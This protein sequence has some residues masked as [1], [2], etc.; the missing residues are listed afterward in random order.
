MPRTTVSSW[1]AR[2]LCVCVL[3]GLSAAHAREAVGW[4][5]K[6]R[7]YPGDLEIKAK[8]DTGAKTSSIH[9]LCIAPFERNNEKWVRFTVT[10]YSGQQTSLEQK[11]H[12][13]A[14]IKR[15]FGAYQERLVIKLGVCL[16]NTYREAEV[17]LIDRS[18][19]N[20]QVLV[21]REFLA[22]NFVVDPILAFTTEP[23]CEEAPR[24]EEE[25]LSK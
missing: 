10:N 7:I 1:L 15:H 17:T 22:G 12:R 14:K 24:P 2:G 23:Q 20:Y 6:V 11:V 8:I 19:L 4:V 25:L 9:C 3:L 21:G 18:G 13:I 5:E 16:K